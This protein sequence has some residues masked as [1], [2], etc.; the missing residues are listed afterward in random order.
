[1]TIIVCHDIEV[2]LRKMMEKTMTRDEL[3][4]ELMKFPP[5]AEVVSISAY[6]REVTHFEILTYDKDRNLIIIEDE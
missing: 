4:Q 2:G 3:V 6:H 5:D 1:M